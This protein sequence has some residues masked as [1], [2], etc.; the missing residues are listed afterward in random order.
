MLFYY[1]S[2]GLADAYTPILD[3]FLSYLH[4][5]SALR[6]DKNHVGYVKWAR[7]SHDAGWFSLGTC[8]L[9]FL[10]RFSPKFYCI[11]LI[12]GIVTLFLH[13]LP[14]GLAV[15]SIRNLVDVEPEPINIV[16]RAEF[17]NL[18]HDVVVVRRVGTH[19][20]PLEGRLG[21]IGIC[22]EVVVL[23]RED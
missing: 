7:Y 18:R 13:Q 6:A 12:A 9:V 16:H 5:L 23:V 10:E 19:V 22:L 3:F 14:A 4:F 2:T 8:P 20:D 11:R 1:F 15:A 17:L 21:I